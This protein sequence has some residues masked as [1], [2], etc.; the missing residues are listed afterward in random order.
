MKVSITTLLGRPHA[1]KQQ[2]AESRLYMVTD[3]GKEYPRVC[4]SFRLH[5]IPYSGMDLGL[6]KVNT[7]SQQSA[8]YCES[9]PGL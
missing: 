4:G 3:G 2:L 7:H 1:D 8:T 6:S 5:T 9:Q